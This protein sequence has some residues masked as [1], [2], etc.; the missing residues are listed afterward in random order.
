MNKCD[1]GG[2]RWWDHLFLL[3]VIKVGSCVVFDVNMVVALISPF[4]FGFYRENLGDAAPKKEMRSS[5]KVR[6]PRTTPLFIFNF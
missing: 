3:K 2:F 5:V 1:R 6:T 4:F